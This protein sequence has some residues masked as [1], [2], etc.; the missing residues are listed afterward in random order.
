ML[1]GKLGRIPQGAETRAMDNLEQTQRDPAAVASVSAPPADG[2]RP[3]NRSAMFIVFLVVFIDLLG[4]GIVLPLL[5]LYGDELLVP[6]FPSE[7]TQGAILGLLMS[8]FSAMQFL[9]APL[10]G[11]VSDRVGRRPI[12]LLGLTGSAVFYALFG[13]ASQIGLGDAHQLALGLVLLFVARL[14]AGVAG[15]TISTAQ[16]VIADCTTPDRRA[17][18]MA[19]IGAASGIGFTFG[20]LIGLGSL[21]LP[22]PGAPGFIA[23]AVSLVALILGLVLF[24]ETLRAGSSVGLR[25]RWFDTRAFLDVLRTPA[26]G[27]LVITFFLATFAFGS[28]ESTLAL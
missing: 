14:G 10:W 1:A 25:R 9:F 8:S 13:I 7:A 28:L 16:A 6:L 19:L 23:A 11:R 4:F 3:A 27:V 5:P 18:G 26:L 17:H 15:A 21:F 24:K 2:T 22:F 12:L 20:P